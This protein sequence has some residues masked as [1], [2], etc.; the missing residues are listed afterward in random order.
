MKKGL[1]GV[2]E[3]MSDLEGNAFKNSTSSNLATWT[4]CLPDA[5]ASKTESV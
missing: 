4:A 5:L 1:L 2:R 3:E